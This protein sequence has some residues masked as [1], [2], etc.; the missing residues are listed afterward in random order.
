MFLIISHNLRKA[1]EKWREHGIIGFDFACHW[2]KN[3]REILKQ[4]T[5]PSNRNRVIIFNIRLKTALSTTF[6]LA[7]MLA[8]SRSRGL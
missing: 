7:S 6:N 4:V 2:L 1:R 8:Q 5:K 3:W